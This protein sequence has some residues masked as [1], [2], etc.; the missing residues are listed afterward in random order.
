MGVYKKKEKNA[1]EYEK[2]QGIAG[3]R[4]T[5]VAMDTVS[6]L[7]ISTATGRRIQETADKMLQTA[8]ERIS[9]CWC[10][11]PLILFT[12]DNWDQYFIALKKIF[13]FR[14]R[15]RRH[16][17]VGRMRNFRFYLPWNLLYTIVEKIKDGSGHVIQVIRNVVHG[18][19]AL[20]NRVIQESPVSSTINT[21]F[22]ERLNGSFRTFCSRLVRKSY[23]FS[24]FAFYHDAHIQII[25]V[26]Y[27]FVKPH[28]TL[29]KQYSQKT[30]PAMAAGL[31]DHCWSLRELCN[32]PI[33]D[34]SC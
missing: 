5:Y 6:R 20:V 3:D 33:F 27:N 13:G 24:K 31:T 16:R 30:T 21:S 26:Y 10:M 34:E 4:Y 15:P 12:S 25:E 11:F 8:K 28:R 19:P 22:V 29:S 1:T 2:E 18:D 17:R 9:L 32:F 14:H 7:V 23:T